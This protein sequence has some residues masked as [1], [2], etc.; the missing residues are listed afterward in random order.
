MFRV[1]TA[2]SR[3]TVLTSDRTI[4][5]ALPSAL[6]IAEV[7]P[8]I[9]RFAA[10]D[11]EAADGD[12]APISW[13]LSRVGGVAVP[14]SSTLAEAGVVDGDLLELRPEAEE[15]RP[16][17]VED[18][19][20]A[21]EDSVDAAGGVWTTRST[22]SFVVLG[23]S[24]VLGIV[25]LAAAWGAAGGP[26]SFAELLAPT[27]ALLVV[28]VLLLGTWWGA[29]YAEQFDAQVAAGVG[30]GW[31]VLL[32]LT[33]MSGAGA[34]AVV[35]LAVAA[36]L[37]A[38][39]A[40]VARLLTPAVTGHLAFAAVVLAAALVQLVADALSLPLDQVRRVLPVLALLM[41]GVVPRVSLSVGGLA[42]ADYRVRHVGRLEMPALRARYRASNAILIGTALGI[43]VVVAVVAFV[44]LGDGDPWDRELAVVLGLALAMRSRLFSR[45]QHMVSLRVIGWLVLIVAAY[46]WTVAHPDFLPWAVAGF[47]VVM[48]AGVGLASTTMSEI[49]RARVKRVLNLVEYLVI[50]VLLVVMVGA[51]GVYAQMG[52]LFR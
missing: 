34:S 25:G 18:V 33:A 32:G 6:P 51:L 45:I 7:L 8:Q 39:F 24:I 47:A 40:G 36:V 52:G 27:S 11:H 15:V 28:A 14:L 22:R 35:D 41:L 23:G 38:V 17:L 46:R 29:T 16:A 31:S 37:A 26:A 1:Q 2:Y 44:L 43:S 42:S 13:T 19:R 12:S 10:P 9:M 50:I 4:D 48:A 5:L 3:V 30:M 20:D 21:I 49:S